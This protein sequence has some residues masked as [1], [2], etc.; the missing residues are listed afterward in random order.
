MFV[1]FAL[2]MLVNY[3]TDKEKFLFAYRI[4]LFGM[5]INILDGLI[6]VGTVMAVFKFGK[7]EYATE[8]THRGLTWCVSLL[9]AATVCGAAMGFITEVEPRQLALMSRNV[10]NLALAMLIGYCAVSNLTGALRAGYVLLLSS[11]ASAANTL[12][13]MRETAADISTSAQGETF[14]SLRT[15]NMGG[16]L[17]VVCAA[18]LAFCFVSG[19]GY[20]PLAAAVPVL[21]V[22]ATASFSLPHRSSYLAAAVTMAYALLV[23]PPV[24][25]GR[26]VGTT[27]LIGTLLGVTLLAGAAVYSRASGRDFQKFVETRVLSFLPDTDIGRKENRPWETRMPGIVAE[28]KIWLSSP[29]LGRGFGSQEVLARDVAAAY[30]FRHNVWTASL[31]EGGL[32]LFLGYVLPCV[33]CVVVGGRMVRDR[34]DRA[35]FLVGAIAALHGVMMIM[36]CSTTMAVNQQRPAIPLGLICGLVLRTRQIQ[37][38]MLREYAGYLPDVPAGED[39]VSSPIPGNPAVAPFPFASADDYS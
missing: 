10:L 1:V 14:Q 18:F 5:P 15:T 29:I 2:L 33:L 17:G 3:G 13:F 36:Y 35:T 16:D 34:F 38:A 22:A 30:S 9:V 8:T 4:D 26:R 37:Q 27:V 7:R 21:L 32:P 20:V 6:A 23:L 31:A 39:G 24:R 12:V 28:L 25:M 11:L 19:I